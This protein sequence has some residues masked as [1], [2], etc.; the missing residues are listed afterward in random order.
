MHKWTN[1]PQGKKRDEPNDT[2]YIEITKEME[3]NEKYEND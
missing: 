2:F 3:R 1:K